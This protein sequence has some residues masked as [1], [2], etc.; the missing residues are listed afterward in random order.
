MKEPYSPI[1]RS[2]WSKPDTMKWKHTLWSSG[3]TML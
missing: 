1:C 2:G 3:H